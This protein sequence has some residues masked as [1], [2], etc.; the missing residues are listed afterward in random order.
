MTL[1][2]RWLKVFQGGPGEKPFPYLWSLAI[3][4]LPYVHD[5]NWRRRKRRVNKLA[6]YLQSF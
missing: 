1:Y 4:N 5:E 6:P 2:D 3:M